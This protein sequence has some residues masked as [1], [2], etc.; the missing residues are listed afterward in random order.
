MCAHGEF[1]L[2]FRPGGTGGYDDLI[3][4]ARMGKVGGQDLPV[5]S[6]SDVIR[7]TAAAGRPTDIRALPTLYEAMDRQDRLLRPPEPPCPSGPTWAPSADPAR[8]SVYR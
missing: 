8:H 7:S 1:D 2:S 4:A 5:A 3:R 6:L